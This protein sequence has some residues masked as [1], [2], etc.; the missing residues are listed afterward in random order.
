MERQNNMEQVY[1]GT[2]E[3][4]VSLIHQLCCIFFKHRLDLSDSPPLLQ[5]ATCDFGRNSG[6]YERSKM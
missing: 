4:L 6:T 1:N 5:I 3:D 2:R